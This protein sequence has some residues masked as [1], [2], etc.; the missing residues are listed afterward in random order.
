MNTHIKQLAHEAALSVSGDYRF[1]IPP[2]FSE[3]FAELLVT[4][5]CKEIEEQPFG[6][7]DA[8]AWIKAHFGLA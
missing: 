5:I 1:H 7:F 8:S 2:E 6:A 4:K 3:K